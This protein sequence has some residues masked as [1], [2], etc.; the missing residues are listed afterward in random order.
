MIFFFIVKSLKINT[1][2]INPDLMVSLTVLSV[3]PFVTYDLIVT[4][5]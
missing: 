3:L 5:V 4:S 2:I 1:N